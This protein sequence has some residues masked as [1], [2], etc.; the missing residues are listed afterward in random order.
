MAGI[1]ESVSSNAEVAQLVEYSPEERRVTSSILVLGTNILKNRSALGVK[2]NRCEIAEFIR[3]A[4]AYVP[5][6]D[7][8]D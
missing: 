2:A 7:A 8:A 1:F 5:A 4:S 3:R 6:A